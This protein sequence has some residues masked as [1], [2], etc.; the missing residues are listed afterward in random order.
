M[1]SRRFRRDNGSDDVD[2]HSTSDHSDNVLSDSDDGEADDSLLSSS[3]SRERSCALFILKCKEVHRISQ[4]AINGLVTDVTLL[5]QQYYSSIRADVE[6]CFR[7]MPQSIVS[8]LHNLFPL[9]VDEIAPFKGL[10][11]KFLQEKYFKEQFHLVV[12]NMKY[13]STYVYFIVWHDYRDQL[14]VNWVKDTS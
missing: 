5:M 10:H 13:Y 7:D 8:P 4:G 11:S 14:S 3:V 2:A 6:K 12:S 1:S 9:P